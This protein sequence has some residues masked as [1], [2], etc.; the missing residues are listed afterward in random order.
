MTGWLLLAVKLRA[1]ALWLGWGRLGEGG[2]FAGQGAAWRWLA[3]RGRC[4]FLVLRGLPAGG[5]L[6]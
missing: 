3:A 5:Q 2:M 4:Q 1:A 6:I